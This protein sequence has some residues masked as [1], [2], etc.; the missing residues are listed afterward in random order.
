MS[1]LNIEKLEEDIQ[2]ARQLVSEGK[3]DQ[4]DLDGLLL[5]RE[6]LQ[7]ADPEDWEAYNLLTAHMPPEDADE[8]LI[9]L[10]G[11]LL[12]EQKVRAFIDHRLINPDAFRAANY[13]TY[14]CICLAEA[15]C[16]PGE[17]PKWL[18]DRVKELNTI[19]N[20]MAHKLAPDDVKQ[21]I[22]SFVGT[23]EVKFSLSSSKLISAI[24]HL[25][26]M[27]KGLVDLSEQREFKVRP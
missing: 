19:R 27:V 26:G 2:T 11:H 6:R 17:D 1:D 14:Q 23:V 25:Y 20:R 21:K 10:R 15:F 7:S 24:C 16:L 4:N 8:T 18:W 3:A 13:T 12:I 9:I 22:E 5:L